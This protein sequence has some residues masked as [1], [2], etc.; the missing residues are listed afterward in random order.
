MK[1]NISDKKPSRLGMAVWTALCAAAAAVLLARGASEHAAWICAVCALYFSGV[2]I[3]LLAWFFG[4][5]RYDA[6]SYNTIFF[7]GFALFFLLLV[8]TLSH[9]SLQLFRYPEEYSVQEILTILLNSSWLYMLLSFP[10]I[11]IFALALC[12]SNISLIRLEG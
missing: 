6:Y 10:L 1:F 8:V 5:L 9:L 4:Q 2:F 12:V 11:L 3:L 7:M